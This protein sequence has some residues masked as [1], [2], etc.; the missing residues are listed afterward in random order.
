MLGGNQKEIFVKHRRETHWKS[1][2][3]QAKVLSKKREG[4]EPN[5]AE[6]QRNLAKNGEWFL[7]CRY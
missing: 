1:K 7:A 5:E 4:G 3:N 6:R 2:I